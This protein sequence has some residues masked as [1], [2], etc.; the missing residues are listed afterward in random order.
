MLGEFFTRPTLGFNPS[1]ANRPRPRSKLC[2]GDY[3]P[4]VFQSLKGKQATAARYLVAKAQKNVRCFNPSKANRPRPRWPFVLLIGRGLDVSIPQRQTGHGRAPPMWLFHL[5]VCF[6]PSKAN[7][8]RPRS[9]LR[10]QTKHYLGFN[11][12]KANRPRPRLSHRNLTTPP[13]RFNPS[14]ANRPRSRSPNDFPACWLQ[15]F[16]SLRGKQVTAALDFAINTNIQ[17]IVSIP[18]RQ[19]GHGRA[20]FK[21]QRSGAC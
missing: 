7:R 1:K 12:S 15:K 16:Q 8:L 19:T 3:R 17:D 9:A 21:P 10:E 4:R 11:P 14:K 2:A 6:N 5:P 20:H 13:F 18:Q